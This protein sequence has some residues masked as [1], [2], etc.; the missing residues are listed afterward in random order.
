MYRD[1]RVAI[2]VPAHNEER[3]VGRVVTTAPD[4][5]DHIMVVDDASTD[6]HRPRRRRA[7]ADPGSR[8]SP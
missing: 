8:S 7:T 2:V 1:L 4:L 6:A 3:L 5:V